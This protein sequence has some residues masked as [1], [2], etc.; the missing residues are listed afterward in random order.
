MPL[1]GIPIRDLRN[2]FRNV[3]W[4]S[5]SGHGHVALGLHGRGSTSVDQISFLRL[6]PIEL[7]HAKRGNVSSFAVRT[8]ASSVTTHT[9]RGVGGTETERSSRVS[10][11]CD[12][13]VATFQKTTIQEWDRLL[14]GI[15]KYV[16][17]CKTVFYSLPSLV[18]VGLGSWCPIIRI[19]TVQ[20]VVAVRRVRPRAH[21]DKGARSW[22]LDT[23]AFCADF[24]SVGP[25][26][27][28][29]PAPSRS[30]SCHESC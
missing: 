10:N 30:S 24:R 29:E 25:L 3:C 12:I 17:Q 8:N 23:V 27:C 9:L 2:R 7:E 22:F 13:I 1:I 18:P 6:C 11:C 14:A 5:R 16:T 19:E 20:Q 26:T 4:R 28:S 15:E 21:L